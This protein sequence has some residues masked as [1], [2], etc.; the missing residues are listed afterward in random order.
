MRWRGPEISGSCSLTVI[1]PGIAID[2]LGSLSAALH[3]R[4]Q[5]RTGRADSRG[6]HG[7]YRGSIHDPVPLP[8]PIPQPVM[9]LQ[10][11]GREDS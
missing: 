10:V 6:C 4:R 8:F 9:A 11:G 2:P 7:R 5:N 1:G 3:P